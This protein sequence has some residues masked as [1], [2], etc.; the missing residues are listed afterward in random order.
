M[1]GGERTNICILLCGVSRH[2]LEARLWWRGEL[3][4]VHVLEGNA[5]GMA[6]RRGHRRR[7]GRG[8]GVGRQWKGRRGRRGRARGR[9]EDGWTRGRTRAAAKAGRR[10]HRRVCSTAQPLLSLGLCSPSGS[11]PAL[12]GPPLLGPLS[13]A[14]PPAAPR[15]AAVSC[16]SP[17]S[18]ST[19]IHVY[20]RA[21][22][23]P[24]RP[25]TPSFRPL[26]LLP[27]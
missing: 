10:A 15:A 7:R 6:R 16:P 22:T 26:T 13:S 2:P 5:H 18:V 19:R 9:V 27:P 11:S 3:G 23:W 14:S 17:S 21:P 4:D 12:L 1:R 25:P 8:G 24:P 20:A